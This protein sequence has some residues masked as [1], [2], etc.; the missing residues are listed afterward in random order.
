MRVAVVAAGQAASV[1]QLLGGLPDALRF[2][3][4]L[5]SPLSPEAVRSVCRAPVIAVDQRTPVEPGRVYVVAVDRDVRFVHGDLVPGEDR[6]ATARLDVLLRSVADELGPRTTAVMLAGRGDGGALGIPRVKQVGGWTFAQDADGEH[7]EMPRAAIATGRIDLVLPIDQLAARLGASAVAPDGDPPDADPDAVG[8][9]DALRDIVAAVRAGSGHDVSVYRRA[10]LIRRVARR[11]QICGSATVAAYRDHLRDRP[12]ELANLVDDLLIRPTQFFRDPATLE[13]IV[14]DVMPGLFSGKRAGDHVRIWIAGCATGEEVYSLGILVLEHA[15]RLRSAP[16]IQLFATDVDDRAL[17]LARQGCYPPAIALDVAPAR[18][19]R[20]FARDSGRYRVHDE[21][22]E[23]V[24][25][26]R[27]DVL[28]DPPFARLDLISCRSLMTDLEPGAQRRALARFH[29]GLRGAGVL[30]L[31]APHAVD[32]SGLFAAVDRDH[33]V[34][35]RLASTSALGDSPGRTGRWRSSAGVAVSPARI[36]GGVHAG[37]VLPAVAA[38]IDPE[39]CELVDELHRTREQLRITVEQYEASLEELRASNEELQAIN[40]ELRYATSELEVSKE[41]LQSINEELMAL[42]QELRCKVDEIGRANSDLQNLMTSTEIGV[43]FLDRELCI[44]RFTPRAQDVFNMIP[45]DLGRPLAHL[46]HRL[47]SEPLGQEIWQIA[48][49]VLDTLR[50]VERELRHRDGPC[51]LARWLPYRSIEGRIDGVVVT[52]IDV[53]DLR[54]AVAAQRRSEQALHRVEERLGVALRSAPLAAL[55]FERSGT[56]AGSV[57]A[58]AEAAPG[59]LVATWGFVMGREL[60]AGERA[61][62]PMLVTGH[63]D[64]LRAG[65]RQ[66]IA[67]RAGQ[68][69]ELD[70]EIGGTPRTF[71]FRIEPTASGA[72]AVGFDITPSK[73]AEAALRD[74]DRRKD[75]FLATLS[76]ELRN[77][78]APLQVALEAARLL[79][80]DPRQRARSL[81]I[82]ERQITMLTTLVNELLDLSR[83]SQGKIVLE[84]AIVSVA[85]AL[86]SAVIATRPMFEAAHH[87]LRIDIPD[88]PIEVDGDFRRLVQVFTNLLTN[89]AKYTPPSGHIDVAIVAGPASVAVRVQDDGLGITSDMLPRIFELFV[90]SRDSLERSQGGLGIGLNLVRRLVELHGGTVTAASAGAGH[91]SAFTVELPL[92]AGGSPA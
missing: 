38:S 47:V 25:F 36:D 66:A 20:F 78:L 76:H 81:S 75:E 4:V 13:A 60:D 16:Q 57:V 21:L 92:H 22:R 67:E 64:R 70:L 56:E 44:Q 27:H 32:G 51:L 33:G 39:V 29:Y 83:I 1:E 82:M 3:L 68:R 48:Q 89:A 12:G 90:Q 72:T 28:R 88:R 50:P 37:P 30:L 5:V 24:L 31:D 74:A 69:A 80:D 40:D 71:D 61:G 87:E 79:D 73:L 53:T 35:A 14:C 17:A 86:E 49:S 26:A 2:A 58:A 59:A 34:F 11:M 43:V 63:D 42:N 10:T 41:E 62:L 15:A 77:P 46:T 85:H 91:G 9:A 84:R 65:V 23:L 52:F 55:G 8:A 18:L 45:S 54:D 7:G 19:Q 6:G